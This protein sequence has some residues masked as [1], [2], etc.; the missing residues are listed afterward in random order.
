MPFVDYCER[1]AAWLMP[2]ERDLCADCLALE[3]ADD[4]DRADRDDERLDAEREGY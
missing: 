4:Y 1:C 3:Y 2:N